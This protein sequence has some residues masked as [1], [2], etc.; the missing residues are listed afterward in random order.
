VLL[1]KVIH[2]N[3]AHSRKTKMDLDNS[4]VSNQ[5][6][7]VPAMALK[8]EKRCGKKLNNVMELNPCQ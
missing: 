3:R 5:A 7:S 2:D 4:L 6:A 8:E 1:D